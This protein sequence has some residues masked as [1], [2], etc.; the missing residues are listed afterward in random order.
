MPST[1]AAW[2]PDGSRI[3]IYHPAHLLA[4]VAR[5]GTDLRF[6]MGLDKEGRFQALSPPLSGR[7][8]DLAAC[9]MGRIV[10]E[11]EAN[12]GLVHDCEVLLSIRDRLGGG[13]EL[14]WSE[15][16]PMEE[17]EG[18]TL[19]GSPSRVHRLILPGYGSGI[20]RDKLTGTLPPELGGL[21]ELRV[22]DLSNNYLSGSIPP[23]LGS[24]TKLVWLILIDTYLSGSIPPELDN[25]RTLYL[26]GNRFTGCIP[27][28]LWSIEDE[29]LGSLGLPDCEEAV[30]S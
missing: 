27:M 3:A 26:S 19:G 5:D 18:V 23:E 7:P 21:D 22:L 11:P 8:V 20:P 4:T 24:L 25:L 10:R 30:S 14:N 28:A 13:V 9:S 15:S 12:P 29:D 17:W 2:S 1:R 16:A 6:L